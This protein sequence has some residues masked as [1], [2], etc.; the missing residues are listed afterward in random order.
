LDEMDWLWKRTYFNPTNIRK[1]LQHAFWLAD[2]LPDGFATQ[3]YEQNSNRYN[4]FALISYLMGKLDLV[5]TDE[6]MQ[7]LLIPFEREQADEAWIKNM[8][9]IRSADTPKENKED[10][11]KLIAMGLRSIEVRGK[12]LFHE[13]FSDVDHEVLSFFRD[14]Q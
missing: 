11:D 1:K 2:P 3:K 4:R 8:L 12:L 5:Q 6:E 13:E 10:M 14:K 7:Q 9:V